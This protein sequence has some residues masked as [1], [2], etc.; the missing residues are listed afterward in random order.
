MVSHQ[1]WKSHKNNFLP[2]R[3]HLLKVFRN[4][5]HQNEKVLSGNVCLLINSC[6]FSCEGNRFSIIWTKHLQFSNFRPENVYLVSHY[7]YVI[8]RSVRIPKSQFLCPEIFLV[9]YNLY[10][11]CK[12]CNITFCTKKYNNCIF[13]KENLIYKNRMTPKFESSRKINALKIYSIVFL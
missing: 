11:N 7:W 2:S 1:V 4:F 12:A 8:L 10:N 5:L 13:F 6:Y 9:L 3:G